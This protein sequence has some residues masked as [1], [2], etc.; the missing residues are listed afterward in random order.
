MLLYTKMTTTDLKDKAGITGEELE[1]IIRQYRGILDAIAH[2]FANCLPNVT[3]ELE[4][5][6][7]YLM[8]E[9]RD[10]KGDELS[11]IAG[12]LKELELNLRAHV[13]EGSLLYCRKGLRISDLDLYDEVIQ[14]VLEEHYIAELMHGKQVSVDH[15]CS[16]EAGLHVAGDL[17]HLQRVYRVLFANAIEHAARRTNFSYGVEDLEGYYRLN[18]FNFSDKPLGDRNLLEEDKRLMGAKRI[19]EAHDGQMWVESGEKGR[20]YYVNVIFTL[21]KS[22]GASTEPQTP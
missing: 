16:L 9:G 1:V 6:V 8:A 22:H 2:E 21:P 20:R 13:R 3:H 19:I 18:V 17:E 12:R 11:G 7:S 14:H 5:M 15:A 10:R 4:D